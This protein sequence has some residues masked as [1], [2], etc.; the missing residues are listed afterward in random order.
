[1]VVM[2][3][4][5]L[6]VCLTYMSVHIRR[7]HALL[8]R[9]AERLG[10]SSRRPRQPFPALMA[11]VSP[12]RAPV[13]TA[14]KNHQPNFTATVESRPCSPRLH[15]RNLLH[16]QVVEHL[17]NEPQLRNLYGL[18]N[19]QAKGNCLCAT[20]EM[21]TTMFKNACG[22]FTGFCTVWTP[23]CLAQQRAR[24]P[25][26]RTAQALSGPLSCTTT[27]K[28]TL[29]KHCA[30]NELQLWDLDRLL[31]VWTRQPSP[32]LQPRNHAQPGR[33]TPCQ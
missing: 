32:R 22:N 13:H 3:V 23:S 5:V 6:T 15:P 33:R 1:M 4:V 12:G 11:G 2:V 10:A 16:N 17:V 20:T 29:S 28:T 24:R 14:L 8:I 25:C 27:G 21:S 26:P 7:T 31:H 19:S 30:T 18:L 9:V